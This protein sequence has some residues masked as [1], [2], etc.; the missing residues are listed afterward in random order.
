MRSIFYS[1]I[2]W[3]A[4]ASGSSVLI[5]LA[6][7]KVFES[8]WILK[9]GKSAIADFQVNLQTQDVSEIILVSKITQ[10]DIDLYQNSKIMCSQRY[11]HIK[12]IILINQIKKGLSYE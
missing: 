10:E 8:F 2:I 6:I 1:E 12:L 7:K 3:A 9:E 11:K 5:W 4:F